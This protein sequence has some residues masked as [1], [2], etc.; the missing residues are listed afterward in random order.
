MSSRKNK[1]YEEVTALWDQGPA[2][3]DERTPSTQER[4]QGIPL[5]SVMLPHTQSAGHSTIQHYVSADCQISPV[6]KNVCRAFHY[7]A[8]CFRTLSPQ[9]IPLY[10]VMFPWTVKFPQYPRNVPEPDYRT[11]TNEDPPEP[12][13][14]IHS[15]LNLYIVMK[16]TRP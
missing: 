4:M 10:S 7:T 16:F 6:P 13:N 15:T 11:D 8:L 2:D 14:H 5:Y 9:D 1:I 3:K 12:I